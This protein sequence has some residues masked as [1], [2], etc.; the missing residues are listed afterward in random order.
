MTP[1]TPGAPSFPTRRA[2]AE[3][4]RDKILTVA[5]TAFAEQ[6]AEVSM[7]EISRR[8][9][10]G[11][12]TLYRNFPSR[13]ELLEAL[14]LDEIDVV[15][16][17]AETIDGETPGQRFEAWLRRFCESLDNTHHLVELLDQPAA[18]G[19]SHA[20]NKARVLAAGRPLLLAAQQTHEIRDDL[21]LEQI[22]RLV[23]AITMIHPDSG[24]IAPI[25]R[26]ALDGLRTPPVPSDPTER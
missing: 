24:Y 2:K 19:P 8:A 26:T 21:T 17:A 25:L 9:G 18:A 22:L 23:M 11:M 5:R 1:V 20:A 15:C 6:D 3:R 12:A 13:R 16:E 10:I 7:A 4:N 14:Y